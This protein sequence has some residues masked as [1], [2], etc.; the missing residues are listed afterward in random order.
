MKDWPLW[1]VRLPLGDL[2]E[3]LRGAVEEDELGGQVFLQLQLAALSHQVD[4]EAELEDAVHVGQLRE[5]DLEGDPAEVDAHEAPDHEDEWDVEADDPE[6]TWEDSKMKSSTGLKIT[7]STCSMTISWH[8]LPIDE[9]LILC[10][11][12][13]KWSGTYQNF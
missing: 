5:H 13:N 11:S 4:V 1:S 12:C 8:E 9:P 6:Q 10:L 2:D 7:W 3:G